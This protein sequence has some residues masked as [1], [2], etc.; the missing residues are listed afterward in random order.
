MT[1]GRKNIKRKVVLAYVAVVVVAW[2]WGPSS[3]NPALLELLSYYTHTAAVVIPKTWQKYRQNIGKKYR[4]LLLSLL[5]LYYQRVQIDFI[6]FH[7]PS[8]TLPPKTVCLSIKC[9]VFC[10][11][12][13]VNKEHA[14]KCSPSGENSGKDQAR[15]Y[16][17]FRKGMFIIFCEG[18]GIL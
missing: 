4:K 7:F 6:F 8:H 12:N 17:R 15:S 16:Y 2:D 1:L 9:N 11:I 5:L 14:Q 13:V 18:N 10:S 3:N